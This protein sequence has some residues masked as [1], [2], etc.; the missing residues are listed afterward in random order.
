MSILRG[1]KF[2]TIRGFWG[3]P[4]EG[5][6]VNL[7]EDSVYFIRIIFVVIFYIVKAIFEGFHFIPNILWICVLSETFA[8]RYEFVFSNISKPDVGE[9]FF[10]LVI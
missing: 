4:L 1:K 7:I 2:E 9:S 8:E 3:D 6:F 10:L 5:Q